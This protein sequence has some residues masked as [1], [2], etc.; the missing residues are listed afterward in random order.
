MGWQGK[1]SVLARATSSAKTM[2][3]ANWS[4]VGA[5]R[6]E[7]SPTQTTTFQVAIGHTPE[8]DASQ[9]PLA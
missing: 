6:I 2:I 4:L 3:R 8:A 7:L 5:H 9:V 1:A